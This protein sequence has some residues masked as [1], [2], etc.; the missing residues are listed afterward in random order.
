MPVIN[1]EIVSGNIAKLGAMAVVAAGLFAPVAA[2]AQ[3]ISRVNAN[4]MSCHALQGVIRNR[5]AVIVRSRARF[6]GMPLS[7][8][9]VS[10]RRYCF[11]NEITRY[12]EVATRETKYCSVKLCTER[13]RRKRRN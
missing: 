3:Q 8:R 6:T 12:S 9:Y 4:R 13:S 11:Q 10:N 7:E 1:F 5:G 2:D